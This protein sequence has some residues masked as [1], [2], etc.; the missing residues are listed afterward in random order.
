MTSTKHTSEELVVKTLASRGE[1]TIAEI[2]SAA[3]LGRST[4]GAT[5]AV[6]ERART[7]HPPPRRSR[8]RTAAA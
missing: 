6:L 4:V 7:A 5:L 3:G 1:L 2:A 8:E